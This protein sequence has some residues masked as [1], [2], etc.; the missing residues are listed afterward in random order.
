MNADQI[1]EALKGHDAEYVEIRLEESVSTRIQYRGKELEDI[2]EPTSAGGCA[3]AL[4]KGGWG[5]V[6]FNDLD[7]L[8]EKVKIMVGGAPVNQHFADEIGADAFAKDAVEA[9][10]KAKSLLK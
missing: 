5:F 8:R 4:V 10:E 3:R 9:V 1:A 6:S 2:S 7:N